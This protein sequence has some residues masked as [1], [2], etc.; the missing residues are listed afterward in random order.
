MRILFRSL[1]LIALSAVNVSGQVPVIELKRP[2]GQL[3]SV[4]PREP[5]DETLHFRRTLQELN[6]GKVLISQAE[7][8]QVI[9]AD[10][11]KGTAE[12]Q[13]A[14]P[15]GQ[16]IA[17]PAD[18]TIIKRTTGWHFFSN[19]RG[20][21]MLS[22]E[23]TSRIFAAD[24]E[25]IHAA[26]N[27]GRLLIESRPRSGDSIVVSFVDRTTG[28]RL[29]IA[30]LWRGLPTPQGVFRP[31]CKQTERFALAPDGWIAILRASPYRV[32]WR[33]PTGE[34]IRGNEIKSSTHPMTAED[35]AEY[36]EWRNRERP[37]LPRDSVR[38]WPET[39]CAWVSGF[40]PQ[41]TPDG[42]VLVYRVPTSKIH[43]T[44]YDVINRE[45]VLIR[46]LQLPSNEAIVAFGK[47]SVYTVRTTS[48]GQRFF[49]Y[50]W[51]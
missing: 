8:D 35:R 48:D 39:T 51:P 29:P 14:F 33:R 41:A 32:D 3:N 43:S 4:F 11:F 24:T 2:N 50:P 44:M 22:P 26:D 5:L 10:F 40:V 31:V 25:T 36:L 46:Q 49:R 20:V 13:K 17:L 23:R 42:S 45:G 12:V 7:G 30:R 9:L 15:S 38:T 19:L 37:A 47:A 1:T 6:D 21:G 18:S 34:W 27:S 16:L 28:S